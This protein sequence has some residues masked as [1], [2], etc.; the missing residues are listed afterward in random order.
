MSFTRND[1]SCCRQKLASAIGLALIL[2]IAGQLQA[3]PG[4][5][6]LA[7][8]ASDEVLEIAVAVPAELGLD[9]GQRWQLV[10]RVASTEP[11]IVEVAPAQEPDGSASAIKKIAIGSIPPRTGSSATRHFRLIGTKTGQANSETAFRFDALTDKSLGLFEGKRPVLVYNH[12]ILLKA[13]AP[14][15]R[16]RSTY[17]HPIYG[18]DGEVLTD[19]FPQDH[20]HHRGL[21]WAWPHVRIEDTNYDLWDIRG[22]HQ[23]F[24]RWLDRHAG[25]SAAVL[26]VENGWFIGDR[27]VMQERAWFTVYPASASGQ[28]IDAEFTWIPTEKPVTLSGAEEK[29]YG[30]LTLRFAARTSTVI[31]TP[32]G[33]KAEDLAMT[34]LPWADLSAKFG[35]V[36]DPSGAAIFISAD[37]PDY[38]PTWL[39]R[40]YG[41][42]CVGWPGVTPATFQPGEPIRCR[43]R[44]WLHRGAPSQTQVQAT[45]DAYRAA[46][47]AVWEPTQD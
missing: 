27:K 40:H 19:D 16:A 42:L 15:D 45:Y 35:A 25:S 5:G 44:L 37:H 22:I 10:E 30:G 17:L 20:F 29:S 33:N 32:L 8:P 23:R 3:A 11:I 47:K 14:A 2:M 26:G 34:R 41:A 38:P 6:T 21:F 28:A 24:E 4:S 12:G 13:G 43:Y 7:V 39:T 9:Q 46:Q 18:L 1:A 36:P 31:T